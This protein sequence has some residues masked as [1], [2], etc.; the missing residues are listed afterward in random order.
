VNDG[1]AELSAGLVNVSWVV[2][3]TPATG[4]TAVKIQKWQQV[5]TIMMIIQKHQAYCIEA[6]RLCIFLEKKNR[7]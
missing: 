5:A 4:K 6:Q 3:E 1:I 2:C 7:H